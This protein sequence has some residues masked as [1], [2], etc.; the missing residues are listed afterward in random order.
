MPKIRIT[1]RHSD[2]STE[3]RYSHQLSAHLL[4]KHSLMRFSPYRGKFD[5]RCFQR[6]LLD[7]FRG[8]YIPA[9]K[10]ICAEFLL[11]Q[12]LPFFLV[13]FVGYKHNARIFGTAEIFGIENFIPI[14]TK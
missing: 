1:V 8:F 6:L 14:V 11:F 7:I 2:F 9:L 12:W 13:L 3:K 4:I 10:Q 5:L